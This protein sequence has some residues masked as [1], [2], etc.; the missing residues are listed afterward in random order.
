MARNQ[1]SRDKRQLWYREQAPRKKQFEGTVYYGSEGNK[2]VVARGSLSQCV[3]SQEAESSDPSHDQL[4][5]ADTI[6]YTSK[7]L[8][9]GPR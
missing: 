2:T 1:R 6:A 5:N 9:K 4:P 3:P 7:I 8:L